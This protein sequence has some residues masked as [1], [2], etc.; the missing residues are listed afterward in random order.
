MRDLFEL[1]KRSVRKWQAEQ[2]PRQAA[3]LAYYTV[4]LIAPMLVIVIAI[5][6][7]VYGQQA[8]ENQ[9]AGQI[10]QAVGPE[11]AQL[12]QQLIVNASQSNDSLVATLVSIAVLIFSAS[13]VFAQLRTSLNSI[14]RQKDEE[15]SG[16]VIV[17]F[18]RAR[19]MAFSVLVLIGIL[20]IV[21]LVANTVFTVTLRSL[22]VTLPG[23]QVLLH[24]ANLI[25][26]WAFTSLLF[27]LI[28]KILASVRLKWS[29]IWRGAA[30]AGLLFSIGRIALSFYLAN[31]GAVS[32]Y[33]AAGSLV[34]ILLWIYYSAQILLFGAA[35]IDVYASYRSDQ[36]ESAPASAQAHAA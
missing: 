22:L 13:T 20:F 23:A 28:Y 2:V 21:S 26:S 5:V 25:L 31:N 29:H 36:Q 18:I 6:G 24:V 16:S 34:L 33:G 3:A 35:F 9:I 19:L 14:W 1:M 4:F 8:A 30:L 11:A 7:A 12:A 32:T 17:S 10:E 15:E 27:G